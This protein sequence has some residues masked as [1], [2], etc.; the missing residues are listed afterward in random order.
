MGSSGSAGGTNLF[1]KP[2]DPAPAAGASSGFSFGKPADKPASGGF[3]FGKPGEKQDAPVSTFS[4]GNPAEKKDASG[5]GFSF[6][7]PA[8][9]PSAGASTGGFSFG[10]PAENA[11]AGASAGGFSFGKPTDKPASG[12]FSF[13]KPEKKDAPA[14][15][16]SF[17][18]PE[19]KKDA[20]AGGL[21][22]KPVD[23][24]AAGGF[25]FG[26]PEEKKDA[27]AG[28][29]SFGKPEEKKDVPA[30]GFS[31]GKPEE[32]KDAL[33][34][35]FSFG[36]PE[37]KKDAPAGGFSFG[38]PE[39]KK[40][41]PTGGLFGKPAD[42]PAGGFS[43]G[44]PEEKKDAPAGGFSFGKPEEKKDSKPAPSVPAT[45]S[46]LRGK[47]IEEIVKMWQDELDACI[48]DFGRQAGEVAAW[49]RVLLRGG[50]E[51]SK[52]VTHISQAEERQLKIDQTLDYVEQQQTELSALLDQYEGQR[53][54]LL[55]TTPQGGSAGRGMD[56]GVA[57]VEREKA[58]GLAEGLNA[59]LDDVSR[60]L[61]SMIEEVNS[62]TAT[63]TRSSTVPSTNTG[64]ASP[65][66]L[67]SLRIGARD[68][69]AGNEDPIM[70]ISAILNAHLGSLKWIDEHTATL[71]ERLEALRRGNTDKS[72]HD[73]L[74]ASV[75]HDVPRSS[76]P[77]RAAR[78]ASV[79]LPRIL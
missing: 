39:D 2:A 6:G 73:S 27:P 44:K 54:E 60:S 77:S 76:T 20:P 26:K 61:V 3:S 37:E 69:M 51:I 36:K 56:V 58:Y 7:K 50:D 49:D 11:S 65:A 13:G 10:K 12:G 43:F 72:M 24:P 25:S 55:G 38:K 75:T 5:G 22:G 32:K 53:N 4:F 28:G 34:G 31:F 17:G 16:F 64:D 59:Q 47:S 48:K 74:R 78:E 30:G 70:Q 19:E 45:P 9:N 29:F 35:G 67:N 66:D 1:G 21:F 40:D 71:R 63:G 42:K 14:G 79:G 18:K 62:L 8:E 57:D 46:L 23:K 68:S 41:V 52:L 15:G 33:A